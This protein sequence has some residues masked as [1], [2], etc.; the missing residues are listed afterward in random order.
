MSKLSEEL[1]SNGCNKQNKTTT[2][3]C[4]YW[5]ARCWDFS[6][7]PGGSVSSPLTSQDNFQGT[8]RGRTPSDQQGNC[9]E[10]NSSIPIFAHMLQHCAV[11]PA[12]AIFSS[13]SLS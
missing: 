9:Q 4:K 3:T 5:N 12:N 7:Y 11:S 13:T 1:V 6:H 2:N 8:S 10:I